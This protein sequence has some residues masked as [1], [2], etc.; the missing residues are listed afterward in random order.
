MAFVH[1]Y[2]FI[3]Y[4]R[5]VPV[6]LRKVSSHPKCALYYRC[7]CVTHTLISS[8]SIAKMASCSMYTRLKAAYQ[9]RSKSH[10]SIIVNL[11]GY[12]QIVLWNL[13]NRY[14]AGSH[15]PQTC[16]RKWRCHFF[17]TL[18]ALISI[19]YAMYGANSS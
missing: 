13:L 14:A 17:F 19:A 8:W 2:I 12:P 5:S 6:I 15:F 7:T 10:I 18:V 11:C 9:T 16:S 1:M 4:S 3:A